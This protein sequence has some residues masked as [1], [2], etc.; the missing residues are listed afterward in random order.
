VQQN[1]TQVAGNTHK[2]AEIAAQTKAG[3]AALDFLND[4][5]AA[6]VTQA[7]EA[8]PKDKHKAVA[9]RA[10]ADKPTSKVAK[11]QDGQG[12]VKVAQAK[13]LVPST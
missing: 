10:S 2:V 13:S 3:D 7:A 11:A 5:G 4:M 9:G 1:E 6:P 12:Q 8:A